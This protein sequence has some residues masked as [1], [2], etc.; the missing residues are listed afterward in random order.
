MGFT[1]DVLVD[2]MAYGEPPRGMKD[3]TTREHTYSTICNTPRA[4]SDRK[5]TASEIVPAR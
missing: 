2:D 4:V 1:A 3:A 5:R